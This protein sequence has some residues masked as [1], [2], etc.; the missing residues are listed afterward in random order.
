MVTVIGLLSIVGVPRLWW[1]VPLAPVL[2]LYTAATGMSASALRACL[3]AVL[4]FGAPLLGRRPDKLSTLAAAALIALGIAPFQ[5]QDVGFCLSF[6]VMGGLL[7]LYPS[8]VKLFKRGLRVDDAALE[9]QATNKLGGEISE[10]AKRW[11]RLRVRVLRGLAEVVAVALTA[12]LSS[13]PLTAYYFG[14]L[15]PGSLLASLP[16]APL[17]FGVGIASCCGLIVGI[18]S[19]WAESVFNHAAGALAQ[20]MVWVAQ[21]AAAIPGCS[22]TISKPDEWEVA[23]WYTALLV[24]SWALW[25]YTQEGDT[26]AAWMKISPEDA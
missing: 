1:V 15:T 3:M 9:E 23:V 2:L 22:M 18:V 19:P 12:W 25:R 8:L 6:A 10:A 5:L 11:Q 17:L 26:G 13:S 21:V 16:V 20:V 24:L 14:R 4:F 7:L